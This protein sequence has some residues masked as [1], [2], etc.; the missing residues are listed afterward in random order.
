MKALVLV[1]RF[2]TF[3]LFGLLAGIALGVREVWA[4][5]PGEFPTLLVIAFMPFTVFA[6]LWTATLLWALIELAMIA[7]YRAPRVAP[8][9]AILLGSVLGVGFALLADA[10]YPNPVMLAFLI[11]LAVAGSSIVTLAFRG[12]P[13][14][15]APRAPVPDT[16]TPAPDRRL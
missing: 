2:A 7:R 9:T 10:A 5:A 12:R 4:W 15:L 11:S 16:G 1:P 8:V 14:S 13:T 3:P 6:G